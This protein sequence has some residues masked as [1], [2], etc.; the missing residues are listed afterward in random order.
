LT[1]NMLHGVIYQKII[2]FK[3]SLVAVIASAVDTNNF[4]HNTK[5]IFTT[6]ECLTIFM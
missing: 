1:F 6:D 2:L 3:I 4:K 5:K